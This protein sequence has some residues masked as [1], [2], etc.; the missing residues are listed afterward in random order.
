MGAAKRRKLAFFAKHPNCCFCGGITV[1]DTEDHQPAQVFFKDRV[2]PRSFVFPACS[3]CNSAS[4]DSEELVALLGHGEAES[5][6]RTKYRALVRSI[7]KKNPGLV[8]GMMPT[9]REV[10]NALKR[11]DIPK[12]ETVSTS[13]IPMVKLDPVFWESH[14]SMVGRKWLLALHYQCFGISLSL[15]GRLQCWTY[16]N[17][18]I[19]AGRFPDEMLEVTQNLAIPIRDRSYADNQLVIRWGEVEGEKTAAF[20]INL[21]GRLCISGITSD[22]GDVSDWM[23]NKY[24][25]PFDWQKA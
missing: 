22:A 18:D 11:I 20:S 14:F 8:A 17:F 13:E 4:K 19:V 21:H 15:S 7:S 23:P 16:T 6:N 10:R 12:P 5:E 3:R 25:T 24:M 2:W 1:A 9:A